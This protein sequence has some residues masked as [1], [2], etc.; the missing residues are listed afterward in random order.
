[1]SERAHAIVCSESDLVILSHFLFIHV[2]LCEAVEGPLLLQIAEH[3]GQNGDLGHLLVHILATFEL[4][5]LLCERA[6]ILRLEAGDFLHKGRS[7]GSGE[8]P[9]VIFI[10]PK[11]GSG[12]ALTYLFHNVRGSRSR[13]RWLEVEHP[14]ARWS[15]DALAIEGDVGAL[16]VEALASSKDSPQFF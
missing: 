7:L 8:T 3:V 13:S 4:S 16:L 10:F 5:L 15:L 11:V 6:R 9:L 14:L 1:M 2:S 12:T